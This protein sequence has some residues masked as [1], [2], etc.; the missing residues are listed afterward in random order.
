MGKFQGVRKISL[1]VSFFLIITFV[2]LININF[3]GAGGL[4][5]IGAN[6]GFDSV[7]LFKDQSRT[8]TTTQ[9]TPS[10]A[11]NIVFLSIGNEVVSGELRNITSTATGVWWVNVAALGGAG[12]VGSWSDFKFGLIPFS[13]LL[14]Q[15][16]A[17]PMSPGIVL[18]GLYIT[19]PV[20]AEE[21]VSYSIKVSGYRA[22]KD[23][24]N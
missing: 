5:S 17:G 6:Q 14:A 21:P 7:V 15:V 2:L 13:G 20:S 12:A 16:T 22:D 8:F 4:G 3:A 24:P 9:S 11:S 10:G 23:F 19:S 1:A 18:G